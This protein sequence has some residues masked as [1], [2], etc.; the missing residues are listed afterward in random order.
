MVVPFPPPGHK[1]DS[2]KRVR[3]LFGGQII[4][5][6][7]APKLVWEHSYYPHYYLP[8]ADVTAK[9]LQNA[10]QVDNHT[11]YD[12]VVGDT[13]AEEA[14]AV[15]TDGDLSGLAKI[16]FDKAEAWFE[17]D[18]RIYVHPKDP[19]KR[20]E[21]LQ[22]SRHVRVEVD[23][24]EVANTTKPRLLFETGLPTRTYIPITDT[25]L[26]LLVPSDKTSSCPYKGTASYYDIDLPSGLKDGLVWWYKTPTLESAEIKGFVAFYDEKVD[27]WV[28]GVKV[29]RPESI[30]G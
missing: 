29:P 15:H 19:Y 25:R 13:I 7:K 14:V 1:E 18:E 8:K 20:I 30:F 22:S 11:V 28:D 10:K 17:E 27:V 21:I 26:D 4:A 5:D 2:P 9:Y 3:V 12:L 23:G 24:V 6:S 16:A